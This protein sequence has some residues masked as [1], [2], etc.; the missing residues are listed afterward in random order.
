MSCTL[1]TYTVTTSEP[2]TPTWNGSLAVTAVTP[3][4]NGTFTLAGG[5]S[6]TTITVVCGTNPTSQLP[7]IA[8]TCNGVHYK[9][10]TKQ[11]N[12]NPPIFSGQ[13]VNTKDPEAGT[14]TWTA[15]TVGNEEGHGGPIS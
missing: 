3:P 13:V 11:A 14:D 2:H 7:T 1:A 8:F 15:E 5:S 6:G 4:N 10:A 9:T 12:S